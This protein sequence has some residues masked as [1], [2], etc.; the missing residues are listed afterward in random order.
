MRDTGMVVERGKQR[1]DSTQ[2]P[3]AARDLARLELVLEAVR[4]ALEEATQ[5]VPDI[6]DGLVDADPWQ[7]I[8]L[9]SRTHNT[10]HGR[11]ESRRIKVCPVNNLLFPGARQ[12]VQLKRRRVDRK[13]G[14]ISVKTLYAVTNLT[15][16]QATPAKL[17]S[18]IRGHW[19]VAALP[20]AR[21]LPSAF[22]AT[23][24]AERAARYQHG[25]PLRGEKTTCW[26]ASKR[27][28][29]PAQAV[30]PGRP[31]RSTYHYRS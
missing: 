19:K 17:A 9:P 24:T 7:Q 1:T 8:P 14:K 3:A 28:D 6:L 31:S 25:R 30:H 26:S 11:G 29:V 27:P 22:G 12:A 20:A 21:T 16:E 23:E 5:R 10:W 18:L 13:T 15:A 4:A 2:V